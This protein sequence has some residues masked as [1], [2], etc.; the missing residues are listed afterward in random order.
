MRENAAAL[1]D[2]GVPGCHLVFELHVGSDRGLVAREL[3]GGDRDV[4][5]DDGALVAHLE[6][7]ADRAS[8]STA[9]VRDARGPPEEHPGR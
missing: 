1:E 7:L 2:R 3:D 6:E 8:G 4:H 9:E 5:T